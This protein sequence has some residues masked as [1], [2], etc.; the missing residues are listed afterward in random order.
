MWMRAWLGK[1]RDSTVLSIINI[2][3]WAKIA[4]NLNRSKAQKYKLLFYKNDF[5]IRS[6]DWLI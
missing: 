6:D 4:Y 2:V 5:G 3:E 1:M